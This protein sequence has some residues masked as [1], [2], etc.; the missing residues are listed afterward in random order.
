[1]LK[2]I[3]LDIRLSKKEYKKNREGLHIRLGTLQRE[4][5]EAGLPVVFIFE[6][7]E[8]AGKGTLL[9]KLTQALDPRGFSVYHASPQ[10]HRQLDCSF[11]LPFWKKTPPAGRILFFDKSWYRYLVFGRLEG[12][13]SKKQL[14]SAYQDAK[15]FE[16]LMCDAGVLVIKFF[17]HISKPQQKKRLSILAKNKNSSWRITPEVKKRHKKYSQLEQEYSSMLDATN[18]E[19]A[20]WTIVEA[21]DERHAVGKIFNTA[22]ELLE[23]QLHKKKGRTSA[24]KR[25]LPGVAPLTTMCSPMETADLTLTLNE[26]AYSNKLK[27]CQSRLR[28]LGYQIYQSGLPVI[29]VYEGWDAAGKG[30]NIRRL[31]QE[32]DPR[33]YE[34]VPVAAPDNLEKSHHYL[35]RFWNKMPTSGHITIFDRSWYGRVLVERVENLCPQQDWQRAYSEIR[36][37]EQHLTQGNTVIIK[38]WLQID[39]KEQLKRFRE[40]ERVPHKHWKL[41]DEDWRN[42]KK[43]SKYVK[44]VED[45]ISQTDTQIAPWHVIPAN[46]KRYARIACMETVLQTVKKQLS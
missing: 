41:T 9:S 21:N 19:K 29:I 37:M 28:D 23:N 46:C 2:N 35:W 14:S 32:I 7:W 10:N 31:V 8:A 27:K 43:Y 20:P 42:R 3:D 45:M 13:L 38:F 5:R 22:I 11:L 44:A 33:G 26:D 34:V 17:L 36:N 25:H 1:M 6:G 24:S 30:G 16:N 4:A 12:S 15:N 39:G 40:R 18:T